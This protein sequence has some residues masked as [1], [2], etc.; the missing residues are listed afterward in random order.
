MEAVSVFCGETPIGFVGRVPYSMTSEIPQT[1][2]RKNNVALKEYIVNF[3]ELKSQR[4]ILFLHGEFILYNTC[5]HC[6]HLPY[7]L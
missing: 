4:T 3:Q 1:L 7:M 6:L 5:L 2:R